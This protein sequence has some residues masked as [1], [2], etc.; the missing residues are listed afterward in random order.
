M[1]F[2]TELTWEDGWYVALVNEEKTT[3]AFMQLD[4]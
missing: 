1:L 3:V 4:E 2:Y